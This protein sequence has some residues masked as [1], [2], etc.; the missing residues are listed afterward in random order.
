M[1][2]SNKQRAFIEH[3]IITWNASEAARRAGYSPKTAGQIG[4][5]LLKKVEIIEAISQRLSSLQM[6]ADEVKVRLTEH[7]RGTMA[8]FINPNDKTI[9]LAKAEK[10]GVL[11]L[12]KKYTYTTTTITTEE[13][14]KL[15]EHASVEL[16]DAQA[17]LVQ[18]ARVHGVFVDKTALTD[19][20]GDKEY[21]G[22]ITDE[23]RDR[24]LSTFASALSAGLLS[25]HPGGQSTVD[26]T[27]P[28]AMG[29]ATEPSG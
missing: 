24:A 22:G 28:G 17:A 3:Y 1:S 27:E 15:T 10:A 2:L 9:D 23:Q 26:T 11:H 25:A 8:D 20:S 5:N 4:F 16:Y 7:G 14:E 19:P 12:L 6:S 29:G 18:M 13:S 21:G